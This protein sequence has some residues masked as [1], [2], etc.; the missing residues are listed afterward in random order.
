MS[1]LSSG[2]LLVIALC[3]SSNAFSEFPTAN[4]F[5]LIGSELPTMTQP[6][7]GFCF[8]NSNALRTYPNLFHFLI[9]CYYQLF[10]NQK[11]I[12]H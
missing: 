6:L 10:C 5:L 12:S 1:F 7:F 9:N 11:V 2:G 4:R 3:P 8:Y